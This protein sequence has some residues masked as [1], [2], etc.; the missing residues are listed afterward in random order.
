MKRL[1]YERKV[2]TREDLIRHTVD[3]ATHIR[4][5]D[6]L[7]DVTRSAAKPARNCIEDECGYFEN[8]LLH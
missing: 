6:A 8:L 5:R 7:L 2:D 1:A 3:A 4:G